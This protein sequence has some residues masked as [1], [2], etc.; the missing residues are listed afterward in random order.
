M[1]N[2]PMV[3]LT[4]VCRPKQWP[5]ISGPDLLPE[6]YPVFGA[7]GQI[8]FYS[9]YNHE[10]PTVLITCRG[11][12]CGTINVSAPCSY[13][14]GNAMALDSLSPEI[15]RGFLAHYLRHRHLD[16]VI[17]GS[18]QP[19]ITREGLANLTIP[20]PPFAEQRRIAAILDQAEAL[21]TK[22]RR[23]LGQVDTLIQSIFIDHFNP[24][25]VERQN[26]SIMPLNSLGKIS[27]GRTPSGDLEGMYGGSIPFLTPGDLRGFIDQP[28][29]RTLSIAGGLQ[30][31]TA[32]AGSTAVCCIGATIGKMGFLTGDSAFNQQINVVEWGPAIDDLYGF[33]ALNQLKEEIIQRGASTTLPI[34]KK[35]SF[36]QLF[37]PVPPIQLQAKFRTRVETILRLQRTATRQAVSIDDLSA[38]LQARAFEGAL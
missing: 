15:D 22:R 34:L 14:T 27:T 29:K 35:S 5:T 38:S 1:V 3:K 31:R 12:T 2:W 33:V 24:R 21:R 19:Q 11:A 16:D 32:R 26:W 25:E 20:R 7:N 8:G 37:L 28:A 23:A 9:T 30:V 10:E 17:S 13:V 4:D 6:G 36:E 18:A